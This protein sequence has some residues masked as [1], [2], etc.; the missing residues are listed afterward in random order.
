MF[1][2]IYIMMTAKFTSP[3][4]QTQFNLTV[5][6][7]VRKIPEGKVATYGQIASLVTVPQGMNPK[8]FLAFS[9]RW[10]GAAMAN[11]PENVP[12]QRVVNSEGKISLPPA[13]GGAQQK[14]LLEGEGILFDERNRINLKIYRWAGPDQDD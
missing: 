2:Y 9:P 5:W 14:E 12:W 3:P 10:V 13:N 1:V 6:E 11:C 4:S 8:D 7:I